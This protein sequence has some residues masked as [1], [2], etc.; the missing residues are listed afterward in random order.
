[1]KRKIIIFGASQAGSIVFEQLHHQCDVI[2]FCDNNSEKWGQS[3]CGVKVISP[4]EL[5]QVEGDILIAS[6]W[7]DQIRDQLL[8]QEITNFEICPPSDLYASSLPVMEKNALKLAQKSK[9]LDRCAAQIAFLFTSA[10]IKSIK[11]KSC[12]E[13]GGGWLLTH[14]MIMYLLGA[15]RII[16]TDYNAIAFPSAIKTAIFNSEFSLIRDILSPFEEHS[17]LR[18][19]LK[20]LEEIDQF[21][22]VQLEKLGIV[23]QAPIDFSKDTIKEKVDL[24]YSISVLEHIAITEIPQNL[25]TQ[26]N[27]LNSGGK[28]LHAVHLEDHLNISENPFKFLSIAEKHY[29]NFESINRGNRLRQ[30]QWSELLNDIGLSHKFIYKFKR[31]GMLPN[32]IDPHFQSCRDL[33]ISHFGLLIDVID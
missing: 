12:L 23:Y 27:L 21:D 16:V 20:K 1:M 11:G 7:Y 32:F 2:A 33:D 14:A 28:I 24:I 29:Q 8:A 31:P 18:S 13:L 3:F 25:L 9:T 26:Y 5:H 15:T 19:R 17:L 4:A 22:F 10:G 30:C 6:G